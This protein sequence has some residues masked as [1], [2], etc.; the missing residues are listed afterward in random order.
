MIFLYSVI[1]IIVIYIVL[2][3]VLFNKTTYHN[4]TGNSYFATRFDK[5][6]NGEY[7]IYK[8]SKYLEKRGWKFLFNVYLPKE[9]GE[10][11]EVDVLL[12]TNKGLVVFESKNYSGWIFG[13][14]NS[15]KW[16]Q[17]LPQGNGKKALKEKFYNPIKQNNT[18]IKYL[19]K[20]IENDA[21][22]IFSVIAFSERCTL[23]KINV[24]SENVV[25]INR[26]N[27][28]RALKKYFSTVPENAISNEDIEKIYST[29]YPFTQVSEEVKQQ[30]IEDINNKK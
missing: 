16:T 19:L 28:E 13:D 29:L 9:N 22:P 7:E 20:A 26:N 17:T 23:K 30:H 4:V 1:A 10:T 8:R 27:V 11:S 18:H 14:E 5:G 3:V 6:R 24:T 25:V 15:Y 21:Y 12:I 2:Q